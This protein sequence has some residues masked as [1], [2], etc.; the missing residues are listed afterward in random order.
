ML[1]QLALLFAAVLHA[2]PV[3]GQPVRVVSHG[4][5]AEVAL[6]PGTLPLLPLRSQDRWERDSAAVHVRLTVPGSRGV[7][8]WA[9][10]A[11]WQIRT[12]RSDVVLLHLVLL[13]R[14]RADGDPADG[15][16]RY[17]EGVVVIGSAAAGA[18][19]DVALPVGS[20]AVLRLRLVVDR[21]RRARVALIHP[22]A[23]ERDLA[24]PAAP[25]R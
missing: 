16:A 11:Y 25:A 17:D 21:N 15:G 23:P 24:V 20:H 5:T 19:R 13:T 8:T 18:E 14:F 6:A 10:P 3:L 4:V 7:E 2:G 1:A 9:R 12:A 22:G